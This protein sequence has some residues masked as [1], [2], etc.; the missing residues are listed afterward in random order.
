MVLKIFGLLDIFAGLLLFLLKFN[1]GANIA[2]FF[3]IYLIV[4]ALIFFNLFMSFID[5]FIGGVFVFAIFGFFNDILA[6][7]CVIWLLQKGFFSLL[8]K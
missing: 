8:S 5:F 4:K 3:V 1:I 2:W 6:L 7:L